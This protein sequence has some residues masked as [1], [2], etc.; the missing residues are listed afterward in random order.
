[1]GS[2]S[3]FVATVPQFITVLVSVRQQWVYYIVIVIVHNPTK[4]L[5]VSVFHEVLHSR[6]ALAIETSPGPASQE[7]F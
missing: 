3:E 4:K 7:A 2:K 1:M 5:V 6:A